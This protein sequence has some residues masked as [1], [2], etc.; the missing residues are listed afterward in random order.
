MELQTDTN[1]TNETKTTLVIGFFREDDVRKGYAYYRGKYYDSIRNLVD[2]QQVIKYSEDAAIGYVIGKDYSDEQCYALHICDIRYDDEQMKIEYIVNGRLGFDTRFITRSLRNIIPQDKLCEGYLPVCSIVET[3]V[4]TRFVNEETALARIK[5]LQKKNDWK[6]I[7]DLFSPVSELPHKPNIWDNVALISQLS[8]A[9]AKLSEVYV[10]LKHQFK[11]DNEKNK[12]LAMKKK[13]REETIMLRKRCIELD[14]LVAGYY[15][16]LGYTHYQ[17]VRELM[18]P[19]GRRD[20]NIKE[21]AAK[22]IEYIDMALNIDPQRIPDLYRKGQLLCKVVPNQKLFAKGC[23]NP[24]TDTI[25]AANDDL[26]KGIDSYEKIREIWEIL[27]VLEDKRTK[28]YQKE[29]VKSLYNLASAYGDKAPDL[30]DVSDCLNLPDSSFSKELSVNEKLSV[31]TIDTA[32]LRMEECCA[33]DNIALQTTLN[34]PEP[35]V[36]ARANGNVEGVF[37]LYNTGKL[38]LQKYQLLSVGTSEQRIESKDCLVK[39]EK[40]L[41]S[42]LSFNWSSAQSNQ[43]KDFIAERLA[44][45]LIIKGEYSEA[46]NVIRRHM[47]KFSMYYIRYTLAAA[48]IKAGKRDE[49]MKELDIAM[50]NERSNAEMWK[51]YYMKFA[52]ALNEGKYSEALENLRNADM[53]AKSSGKRAVER[54]VK[55]RAMISK[56]MG[57]NE[58]YSE[59]MNQLR[60]IKGKSTL[61]AERK[62]QTLKA[63]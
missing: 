13:Y 32:L 53:H 22:A 34:L 45:V 23:R 52:C 50:M 39:A 44:R 19:G 4:L 49:A 12:F 54:L 36:T 43:S 63:I 41:K 8:F 29:Y 42:A 48:L 51:G 55:G 31:E 33:A 14:P 24:D 5:P 35:I 40:F 3:S 26:H 18:M 1:T 10:N 28:R 57:D 21:E 58:K 37:K 7:Y 11:D 17:H 27:P 56:S 47:K 6:G 60:S 61:Q 46:A 25:K 9:T 30:W 15:S 2:P 59:A 38:Y 20:G 16:N 62:E